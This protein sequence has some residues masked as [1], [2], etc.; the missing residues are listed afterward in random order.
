MLDKNILFRGF[1]FVKVVLLYRLDSC[2]M[3]Q[4]SSVAF[5]Q[6]QAPHLSQAIQKQVKSH[7][8]GLTYGR[9]QIRDE[10]EPNQTRRG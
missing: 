3:Y 2:M 5:F 9:T 7:V 4:N 10:S 6:V 8:V 1:D